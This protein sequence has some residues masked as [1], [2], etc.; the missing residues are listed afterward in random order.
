MLCNRIA[1]T[2]ARGLIL[3]L[4]IL[5]ISQT[6]WAG[7]V[8]KQVKN[9]R[10]RFALGVGYGLGRFDTNFKFTSK[11]SGRSVF[12]D[13]EGTLGLPESLSF[14]IYYGLFRFNKRHSIGFSYFGVKREST[15]FQLNESRDLNLGDLTL[16]A[17]ANAKVTLTDR[18]SFYNLTYN[19]TIFDD[20]RSF[21]FVSF[22]LYGLD[23][24]YGLDASGQITLQGD[25]VVGD[26]YSAEV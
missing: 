3:I 23:L 24:T 13:G 16:T 4:L 10:T 20:D 17:G 25:P 9:K 12:I 22:G 18:S 1:A 14:P 8:D 15:L 2:L 7:E 5:V 21:L 19:Y 26:S 11:D 6:V